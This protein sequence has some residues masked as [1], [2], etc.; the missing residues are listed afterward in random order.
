MLTK[1]AQS[2]LAKFDIKMV[3][4]SRLPLVSMLGVKEM[5]IRTVIDVGANEGQYAE[6][7]SGVFPEASF[8]CFEPLPSMFAKLDP[9]ARAQQT[10]IT[11]LKYAVGDSEG[12]AEMRYHSDHPASS[13]LLDA[14]DFHREYVPAS[15][16]EEIFEVPLTTLDAV[17]GRG[18][19]KIEGDLL[20]KLDV[21]G[22]EDRVI[23]GG[24]ETF[25][26]AAACVIEV[27]LESFY[28]GQ[29]TFP[30]LVA[31]LNELGLHYAGNL[32]Q[33][34]GADGRIVFLDALF[35]RHPSTT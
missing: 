1:L 6:Y 19:V 14:T 25:R 29:A 15:K 2:A 20:I 22:F 33:V 18:E 17:V 4:R 31:Q 24:P 21:Q 3:R 9:W 23:R 32:Q 35:L 34:P 10:S 28:E 13:S 11:A 8:Y 27:C 5:P 7:L 12:S 26:R 30:V 16:Q